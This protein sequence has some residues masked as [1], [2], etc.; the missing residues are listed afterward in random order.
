MFSHKNDRFDLPA[1]SNGSQATIIARGVR[2]EGE[3][4]S[5]SDVHIEGEVN[6]HVTTTGKL[7]I[8]Q[9]AQV[10]ADVAANSAVIA[11][12]VD[13]SLMVKER[14]DLKS[15]ARVVGDVTCATASIEAGAQLNG[16]VSIGHEQSKGA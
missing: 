5:Q 16:K 10:K 11:G 3:F 2:L 15:T 8:G 6:G 1:D 13:G 7:T 4:A 14:L 12:V 9:A